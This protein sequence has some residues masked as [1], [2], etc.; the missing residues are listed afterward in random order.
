MSDEILTLQLAAASDCLRSDWSRDGEQWCTTHG[1]VWPLCKAAALLP[2]V[3]KARA[4]AWDEGYASAEADADEE[5]YSDRP[6]RAT[7]RPRQN[8]YR[9]GESA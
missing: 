8:P 4:G 6:E 5:P 7:W 2:V 3:R 9:A 1:G